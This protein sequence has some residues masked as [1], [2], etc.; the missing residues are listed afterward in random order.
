MKRKTKFMLNSAT[1]LMYQFITI[2]CG[3]I[4]PR[5]FLKYYGSAT[6]GLISSITQCLGFISLAECGVGAVVQSALYKPLAKKDM[7]SV[8]EIVASADRF[9]KKIAYLLLGYVIVL[10]ICYP[11]ITLNSFDYFFTFILIFIISISTFAQYYIGMTYKLLLH[12]D[13]LGFIYYIVHSVA[14]IVNTVL[15]IILMTKS[16]S[17]QIVKLSSSIIF[18]IQP[19]ALAYI[20]KKKYKINR[21]IKIVGEP[22]KQKWNGLAQHVASVVL[23]NTDSVVLTL[24]SSLEN[25]SIYA[26]YHLV[27]NGVKLIISSLTNGLQAMLGNMLAKKETEKLLQTFE[28]A[29][30]GLHTL[31]TFVYTCTAALIVPFVEVYTL[32][33][34]DVNYVVPVFGYLI[35]LAQ[36]SYCIRLPYNIMVL[37]AGHYKQTQWS[38]IYEA[39]INIVLSI[40][41][42]FWFGLIGVAVGT[43]V[44]MVYRT[45]YFARY[46]AKNIINRPLKH[47]IK[48]LFVD[49]VI[50]VSFFSIFNSF[51]SF[52]SMRNPDYGSWVI[53]AVKVAVVSL[54]IELGINILFYGK[55]IRNMMSFWRNK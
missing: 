48:H 32:D 31:V 18:L 15:C 16:V 28:T 49:L 33:I 7:Q 22:I 43:F 1:S 55:E 30:W 40:L 45:C 14:L 29:E 35:T 19:I 34:A 44:A 10:M 47:F 3:F 9:F 13:Q 4:L 37:A 41:L 54:I 11:F 38:A 8:N 21:K 12:A 39:I 46:L 20:A 23:A 26:V 42:V 36:A 51:S 27:V 6:N 25:V 50:V 5:F 2:L 24:F 17:V 52:F 53:L